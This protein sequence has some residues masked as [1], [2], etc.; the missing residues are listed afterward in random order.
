MEWLS[1]CRPARRGDLK[2]DRDLYFDNIIL[3]LGD[4]GFQIYDPI[5]WD[6]VILVKV[7]NK[8]Q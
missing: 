2:N 6:A 1:N 5:K 7:V 8:K 4:G 3:L